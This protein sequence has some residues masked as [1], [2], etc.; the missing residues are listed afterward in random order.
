MELIV[1]QQRIHE[2]RGLKIILDKDIAILYEVET[3]VLK[4]AVKRNIKRFPKD[5]MFQLTKSEVETLVSQFVIPSKSYFG[6]ALPYA[7][8]EHGVT[9]LASILKSDKAV[10]MNIAVVRAF[11]SLRQIAIQYKELSDK[12]NELENTNSKKFKEIYEAL[13]Y[14]IDKKKNEEDIK[15]RVRIGFKK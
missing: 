6:G 11:V 3:R 12:L 14:L 15:N 7:F 8:T 10:Q 1:I 13:N 4:Q 5:F 2:I 9:M